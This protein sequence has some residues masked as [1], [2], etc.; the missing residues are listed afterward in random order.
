MIPSLLSKHY[1]MKLFDLLRTFPS[2]TVALLDNVF[3]EY[4]KWSLSTSAVEWD[5]LNFD[6]LSFD[7]QAAPSLNQNGYVSQQIQRATKLVI[8]TSCLELSSVL[9]IKNIV[10]QVDARKDV[11]IVTN[12]PNSSL[13][14][15]TKSS[16]KSY[17]SILS[18]LKSDNVSIEYIPIHTITIVSHQCNNINVSMEK[19]YNDIKTHINAAGCF[20]ISF[21]ES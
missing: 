7:P 20:N 11:V 13:L 9:H 16:F 8:L 5:E 15:D 17:D 6:L 18:Y 21:R 14:H 19:L 3:S 12:T 10:T 1:L 2:K 4:F